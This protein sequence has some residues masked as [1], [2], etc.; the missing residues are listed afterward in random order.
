MLF[1]RLKE[2]FSVLP[3]ELRAPAKT[4]SDGKNALSSFGRVVLTIPVEKRPLWT[5]DS[6]A[7]G[8]SL[9]SSKEAIPC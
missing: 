9:S 3:I 4:T 7:A 5:L 8:Q 6:A 2:A 1:G